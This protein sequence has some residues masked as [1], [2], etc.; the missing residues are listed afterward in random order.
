MHAATDYSR[1]ISDCFIYSLNYRYRRLCNKVTFV[2]PWSYC[3]HNE[4]GLFCSGIRVFLP[5]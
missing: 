1:F 2:F 3:S 5:V 4:S